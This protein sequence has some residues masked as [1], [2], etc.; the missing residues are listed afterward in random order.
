MKDQDTRISL[1]V[2][3][4]V[5]CSIALVGATWRAA[6]TL[7]SIQV[8]ISSIRVDMG[9][10]RKDMQHNWTLYDQERWAANLERQN[11]GISLI[12]PPSPRSSQYS[13]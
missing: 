1:T 3:V 2:G 7:S 4:I 8:E 12:V 11:R 5:T 9:S 6:N 10:M 13:N